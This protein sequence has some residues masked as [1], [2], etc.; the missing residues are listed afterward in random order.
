MT[1]M[2]LLIMIIPVMGIIAECTTPAPS[3]MRKF[4]IRFYLFYLIVC[5]IMLGIVLLNTDGVSTWKTI[6]VSA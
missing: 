6:A 4:N 1:I 3:T 2:I 5:V